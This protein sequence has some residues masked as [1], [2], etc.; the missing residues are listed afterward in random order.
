MRFFSERAKTITPYQAGE[1][2]IGQKFI[3]LNTN[4]N[5]YPPAPGVAKAIEAAQEGGALRLYPVPDSRVFCEAVAKHHGVSTDCVFAGNGS[6]EVLALAFLAYFN[7][8][9]AFPEITYS[10][11]PVYAGLY[12]MEAKIVPM[13]EGFK[14]NIEGLWDANCPVIFANPNAPTSIGMPSADILQMAKQLEKRGQAL[15]IDEAYCDFGGESVIPFITQHPNLLVIRTLSKSHSLAGMRLGY[16]I[17]QPELL[18]ALWRVKDS[19]N[20]YP[21]DRLAMAAGAA[22]MDDEA[23]LLKTRD[24]I[25]ATRDSFL[26]TLDSLGFTTPPSQ[27]NFV[28]TKHSRVSGEE[29]QREMR[30]RGVLVRRFTSSGLGDWLRISIGTPQEMDFVAEKLQEIITA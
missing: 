13:L 24:A 1:Q 11:Y 5:P 26:L 20:S 7:N 25:I 3:K 15:I 6:D 10:F 23:Y 8:A 18:G 17:G 22:A 28:F 19:F 14:I 9:V 29:I 12:G 27:A 2:P 16:A 4:E 30:N 21:I